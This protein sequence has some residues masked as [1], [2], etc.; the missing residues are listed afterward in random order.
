MSDTN[1]DPDADPDADADPHADLRDD[2]QSASTTITRECPDCGE[3]THT[4][5]QQYPA[6]S[7]HGAWGKYLNPV[8]RCENCG[9]AHTLLVYETPHDRDRPAWGEY[10]P[11]DDTVDGPETASRLLDQAQERCATDDE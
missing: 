8:Y 1:P 9:N 3:T 7:T 2:L 10:P 4:L 6:V 11:E 5:F